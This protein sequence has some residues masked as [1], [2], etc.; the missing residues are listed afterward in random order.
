MTTMAIIKIYDVVYDTTTLYKKANTDAQR[1]M[2]GYII[3]SGKTNDPIFGG[4]FALLRSIERCNN[5]GEIYKL[6]PIVD[7]AT[8]KKIVHVAQM[9]LDGKLDKF[10]INETERNRTLKYLCE[11]F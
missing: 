10:A 7:E 8:E 3:K 4:A 1:A 5:N 2:L 9:A 6:Y 11:P